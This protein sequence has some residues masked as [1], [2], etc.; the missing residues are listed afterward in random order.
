MELDR[1]YHYY[2]KLL[3]N[4]THFCFLDTP[5][6]SSQSKYDEENETVKSVKSQII[7]SEAH[8]VSLGHTTRIRESSNVAA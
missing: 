1:T 3:P 4:F 6:E 8:S 7:H 2:L 5:L